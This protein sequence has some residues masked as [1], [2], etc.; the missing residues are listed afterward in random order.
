M[1]DIPRIGEPLKGSCL[2]GGVTITIKGDS[3]V[4]DAPQAT[5]NCPSIDLGGAGGQPV[6][7]VGDQVDPGTH[8]IISG[9]GTVRATG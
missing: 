3:V 6:A 4:I 1:S 2:C 9:S 8:K 7:R 5:I